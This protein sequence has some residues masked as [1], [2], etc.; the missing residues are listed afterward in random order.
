MKNIKT[1]IAIFGGSFDPIHIGHTTIIEEVFKQFS[2]DILIILPN[3]LNPFKNHFFATPK[4]RLEWLKVLY[5]NDPKIIICDYEIKQNVSSSSYKSMVYLYQKYQ[6]KQKPYFIIG[7]DNLK[8]LKNWYNFK[9]LNTMVK[10]MVSTRDNINIPN[11]FHL[12]KIKKNISSTQIREKLSLNYLPLTVAN[13]I[14]RFYK[15]Q[16]RID[17]ITAVLDKNKGENIEV[18]DLRDKDYLVDYAIIA[19]TIG[20]KHSEALLNYMKTDL[21]PKGEEFGDVES[22]D[23]WIVVDLGDIFVHLMSQSYR[24]KYQLDDFM[25]EIKTRIIPTY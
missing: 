4:K 7:A 10:W 18:F 13:D 12:L 9:Q 11:G 2:L 8:G 17:A 25:N 23:E 16:K 21:K 19:T 20:A 6:F 5:Q 14:Q 1:K 3:F 24:D 22:D 15:M